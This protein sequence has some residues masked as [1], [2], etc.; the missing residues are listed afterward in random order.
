MSPDGKQGINVCSLD[1][2]H[3]PHSMVWG[4]DTSWVWQLDSLPDGTTRLVTRIRSRIRWTPMSI[5]F[6]GLMELG[7]FWMIRKMLHGLR[8]R[9]EGGVAE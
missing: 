5:A 4:S 3:A 2:P 6:S 9:A 1:A 8:E 7:D